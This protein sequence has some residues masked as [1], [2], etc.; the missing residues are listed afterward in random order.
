MVAVE[1]DGEFWHMSPKFKNKDKRKDNFLLE[2]G[3]KIIRISG[4]EIK[5]KSKQDLIQMF[6][7]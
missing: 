4:S 2:R 7:L 5:N 6:N 1:C 3:Y